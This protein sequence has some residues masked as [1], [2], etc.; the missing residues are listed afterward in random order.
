VHVFALKLSAFAKLHVIDYRDRRYKVVG[1]LVRSVHRPRWLRLAWGGRP[2]ARV[3][4]L[5]LDELAELAV[6]LHNA[7]LHG[8]HLA[9]QLRHIRMV[10]R[11]D[12]RAVA[13]PLVPTP[14]H[15]EYAPHQ[16]SWC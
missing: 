10:L 13:K 6:E 15:D 7:G 3:C 9:V 2:P 11:R 12:E 4:L 16:W 5:Q 14:H 8:A 1:L